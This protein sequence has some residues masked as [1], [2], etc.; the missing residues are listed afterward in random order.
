MSRPRPI[1]GAGPK[2][3]VVEVEDLRTHFRTRSG[4]ARAV[5][6]VSFSI[7]ERST[8]A[9]VGES[10]CGKSATALSI[11]Q[12]VPE[13]AGF[14]AGGRVL[15]RGRDL[16]GMSERERRDIR[17]ASISMIFQE[18]MTSL[19]PVFTVGDQ[20]VETIRRHR[21]MSGREARDA[22]VE[23]LGS[24]GFDRP[25]E[26]F[27]EYPH[28]LSGGMRQ[29]V[30]IAMALACRPD[31]LIADEPTT[32][33][34][35]TIQDQIIGLI[36]GLQASLGTAVLLITHNLALVYRNAETVGVMYAGRLVEVSPT[37][38]LFESPMHPYTLK[39]LR[40][41]PGA[42][43][44]GGPLDTIPGSVPPATSRV[45]GCAFA[46]RCHREM[47][48]CSSVE[49]RLEVL[50][51]AP[52]NGHLVACH[53]YDRAFA[54]S[55]SGQPSGRAIETAATPPGPAYRAPEG[56]EAVL[57]VRGLKTYYPVRKGVFKRVAGHVKAVDGISL[58]VRKGSTLA[59]VGESG[60]GKTTA[61]KSIVRLLKPSAGE[62]LY[63]GV[64]IASLGEKGLRPYRALIQMIF[65]D[66]YSSLD[67]RLMIRDIIEEGIKALRPSLTPGERV[68]RVASTLERVGLDA[69]MMR[70]YP[71]E[72]SGGQRQRIGIARALAVDP[73]FIVCDE[74]V[75]SLDVSVQAQILNLLKSIQAGTGIS[76]LFITHDIGVVEYVADEV[77]V[78]YGGRIVEHGG[79]DEVLTRPRHDYTRR[80]L[81]AVPRIDETLSASWRLTDG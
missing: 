54:G 28:T 8:F 32:A 38:E 69:G 19:N 26:V 59:L 75:S 72:F 65:Q 79:V 3:P 6:G 77:A 76:Y 55:A 63:R 13:P 1:A 66:P 37:R 20:I 33:L 40:S 11:I 46:G 56:G 49:P 34:D 15:F 52:E 24:V 62:I 80:L 73:E 14:I 57:E 60:C 42:G 71:H 4:V 30:M 2:G 81:A 17:G 43:K 18:P 10:G 67:P 70:R 5:D 53:L 45:Q 44:R 39:L 36:K 27:K 78:M 41:I 58:K 29:R 31:L 25:S 9:L 35:V 16:V 7:P 50:A 64:D 68:E 21:K 61:G 12:L 22:A 51:P 47:L 74:P 23:M 48:G